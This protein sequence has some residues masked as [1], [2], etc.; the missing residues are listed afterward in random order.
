MNVEQQR[1]D[2]LCQLGLIFSIAAG[3]VRLPET[4][5]GCL[6]RDR[7]TFSTWREELNWDERMPE[8]TWK[9]VITRA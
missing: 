4:E 8:Q 5:R 7:Q 6:E 2:I 3:E 9:A 1:Q